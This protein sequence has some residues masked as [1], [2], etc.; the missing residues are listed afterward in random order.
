MNRLLDLVASII[1]RVAD[2]LLNLWAS[3]ILKRRGWVRAGV[4]ADGKRLWRDA[5]D[6]HRFE[7]GIALSIERARIDYEQKS[8]WYD[9]HAPTSPTRPTRPR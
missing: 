9:D 3:R 7:T 6:E 8:E 5:R 2:A 4:N 1:A